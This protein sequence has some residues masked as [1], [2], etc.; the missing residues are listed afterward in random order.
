MSDHLSENYSEWPEDP[1]KILNVE[2]DDDK[3]TVRRAYNKLIRKFKPDHFPEEFRIIREAYESVQNRMDYSGFF[4]F[5]EDLF[6]E[7]EEINADNQQPEKVTEASGLWVKAIEGNLAEAFAGLKKLALLNYENEAVLKLYWLQRI[8]PELPELDLLKILT[9]SYLK[10]RDYRISTLI[11]REMENAVEWTLGAGCIDFVDCLSDQNSD[12]I[13]MVLEKRWKV[14]FEHEKCHLVCE[15]LEHI[16]PRFIL[17][18]EEWGLIL[19]Q[20]HNFI[21]FQ[22]FERIEDSLTKYHQEVSELPVNVGG[23]LDSAMDSYDYL[24]EVRRIIRT[25]KST[26]SSSWKKIISA[27]W[28]GSEKIY[29][30]LLE[31]ELL[32][33][34]N[35]PDV[36][37]REFEG[38]NVKIYPIFMSQL[39]K[40]V[41]S[42][43]F[44]KNSEIYISDEELTKKRVKNFFESKTRSSYVTERKNLLFFSISQNVSPEAIVSYVMNNELEAYYWVQSLTRDVHG[45]V[46]L[47]HKALLLGKSNE[48]ID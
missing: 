45:A 25:D 12:N 37:L 7:S 35:Y 5:E 21:S 44:L 1:Y 38:V 41:Q 8:C 13:R 10:D 40:I 23:Y 32:R 43:A 47:A 33:W 39:K 30:S 28:A 17:K 6:E 34:I 36:A 14:A 46:Y 29:K 11:F 27:H 16:R 18:E 15:D 20:A 24:R 3:K 42:Y 19:L 22:N 2:P 9:E 48:C 26:I 31:K 4:S